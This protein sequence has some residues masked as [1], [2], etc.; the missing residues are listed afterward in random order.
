MISAIEIHNK[1][2]FAYR[3]EVVTMLIINSWEL[4]L[5]SYLLKNHPEI[6]VIR[7]D[8]TTKPFEECIESVRSSIGLDFFAS[9][10]NIKKI[11]EYRCSCIHFYQEDIDVLLYS[12][13]SKSVE[14]YAD[15]INTYFGIDLAE[16]SNLILLPIGFRKPISPIIY[17]SNKIATDSTSPAVMDFIKSIVTSTNILIDNNLDDSILVGYKLSLTN[18]N[19]IS[20]AD[21]KAA[22]TKDDEQAAIKIATILP[23]N[24]Q[25]TDDENAKKIRL[26]E[27]TLYGKIYTDDYSTVSNNCKNMFSDFLLNN[28][29]REIMKNLKNNPQFHKKRYLDFAR[30]SGSGKDYYTKAIYEEIAKNYST[31]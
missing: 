24:L 5:K 25:I 1:P 18:E 20:N 10:E 4:I 26:E 22:I 16:E 8:R 3:Y 19:R 31:K 7:E 30:Q 23:E 14:F 15:F 11:Y 12:L 28:K 13:S 27:E 29:F 9:A 6:I 17:L 2:M 21:I